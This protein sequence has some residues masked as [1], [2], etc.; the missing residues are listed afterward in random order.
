MSIL[1]CNLGQG[2]Y[3][4]EMSMSHRQVVEQGEEKLLVL[5]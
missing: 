3:I 4:R 1:E 5:N 2:L